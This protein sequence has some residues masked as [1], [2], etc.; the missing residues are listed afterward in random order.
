MRPDAPE[1]SAFVRTSVE[2]VLCRLVQRGTFGGGLGIRSRSDQ[3]T[4]LMFLSKVVI[5]G[6]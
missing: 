6:M 4:T 5:I 1:S 2:F 3:P